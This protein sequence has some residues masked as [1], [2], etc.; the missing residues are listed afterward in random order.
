MILQLFRFGIIDTESLDRDLCHLLGLARTVVIIDALPGDLVDILDALD[1]LAKGGI[2]PVKM[3]GVLV[4]DEELA[5]GRVRIRGAGHGKHAAA[6]QQAVLEA[7]GGKLALDAVA[8]AADADALGIAALD[9]KALNNAVENQSVI[10]AL[11]DQGDEIVD[12]V[13]GDIGIELR[14]DDIAVFHFDCDNGIV[15]I[16]WYDL[17]FRILSISRRASRSASLSRLS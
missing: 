9:H 2:L 5:A 16:H 7:V 14:L 11:I 4:H 15:R 13:G 10:K 6:V 8:G 17:S 12:G 3:R 1:H